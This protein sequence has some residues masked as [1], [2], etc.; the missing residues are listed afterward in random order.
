MSVC[1]YLS[2]HLVSFFVW[3]HWYCHRYFHRIAMSHLNFLFSLLFFLS[4]LCCLPSFFL[5]FCQFILAR[6]RW[7]CDRYF[8]RISISDLNEIKERLDPHNLSWQYANNT[9][10]IMVGSVCSLFLSLFLEKGMEDY[11]QGKEEERKTRKRKKDALKI[12]VWCRKDVTM[13]LP[14]G[15]ENSV[16]SEII[17]RGREI[18]KI[19]PVFEHRCSCFQEKTEELV[20]FSLFLSLSFLSFMFPFIRTP[21]SRNSQTTPSSSWHGSGYHAEALTCYT[22]RTDN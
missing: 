22:K 14:L 7:C 16:M 1:I 5:D 20:S 6:H 13:L 19:R 17:M 9:L 3:Y 2:I 8:K 4:Y 10:L 21:S 18:K 11:I 12:S 15:K